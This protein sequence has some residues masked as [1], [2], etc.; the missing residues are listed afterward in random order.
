MTQPPRCDSCPSRATRVAE[1]RDGSRVWL[2]GR[3]PTPDEVD[4]QCHA[5][6]GAWTEQVEQRRRA[7]AYRPRPPSPVVCAVPAELEWLEWLR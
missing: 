6:R 5:I 7:E 1:D 4:S 3:C 2:C